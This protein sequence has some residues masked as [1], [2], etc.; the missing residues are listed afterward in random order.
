MLFYIYWFF[1]PGKVRSSVFARFFVGYPSKMCFV[2]VLFFLCLSPPN[3]RLSWQ[4]SS[5]ALM[6]RV[7]VSVKK[8]NCWVLVAVLPWAFFFCV[9]ITAFYMV[10]FFVPHSRW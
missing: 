4:E 6:L 7:Q 8:K 10:L 1:H 5:F 9:F 2:S 3:A